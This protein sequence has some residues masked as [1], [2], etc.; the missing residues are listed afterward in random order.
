METVT[1]S[2]P[3]E[4]LQGRGY[5]GLSPLQAALIYGGAASTV[6]G[7][8]GLVIGAGAGIMASRM[9]KS[10]LAAE[11]EHIENL[12]GEQQG[13]KDT[14]RGELDIADPDERRALANYQRVADE[15]MRRLAAG[16]PTGRQMVANANAGI[17]GIINGDIQAR[18]A[19]E[20]ANR[21]F[22]RDLVGTAAKDLRGQFQTNMREFE[23]VD[24]Q[25]ARLME[26]VSSGADL[27]KPINR[28]AVAELLSSGMGMYRDMPDALDAVVDG[29]QW[30]SAL[31][32][33]GQ[34]LQGTIS[35]IV[36]A[37]KSGDNKITAEDVNRLAINMQS[38]ARRYAEERM[39]RLGNQATSL[40]QQSQRVGAT[41]PGY[42]LR[43][44]VSGQVEKLLLNP[45]T[46][47]P[48]SRMNQRAEQ[49]APQIR[50]PNFLQSLNNKAEAFSNGKYRT[51][52]P[53]N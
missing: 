42:S 51:P 29:T 3:E 26:L 37:V 15:G 45:V 13:I 27:N 53:T 8:L 21:N 30:M 50:A 39:Q 12:R 41:P 32:L 47:S 33:P 10:Y 5:S 44:Y 48:Q 6:A 19:D 22:M 25:A 14:I 24:Q 31:G 1:A 40:D 28:S 43:D 46:S 20:A 38:T 52:R 9:K 18:K 36:G 4:P 35:G 34:A 2:T 7:P 23:A 17:E 11:T 16:D 49:P